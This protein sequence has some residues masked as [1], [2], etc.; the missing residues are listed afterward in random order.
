MKYTKYYLGSFIFDWF[1]IKEKSKSKDKSAI[2][3]LTNMLIEDSSRIVINHN[4]IYD[5]LCIEPVAL[6][7]NFS[8][9][10]L[11]ILCY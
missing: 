10:Y 11:E 9:G 3:S 8:V 4:L 1:D 2:Y 6:N 7:R 5:Y